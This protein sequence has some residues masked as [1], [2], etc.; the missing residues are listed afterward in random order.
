MCFFPDQRT[1]KLAT[2]KAE[3][4]RLVWFC[5]SPNQ[6]ARQALKVPAKQEGKC[7]FSANA[8]VVVSNYSDT[9]GFQSDTAKLEKVIKLGAVKEV[10]CK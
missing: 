8:S 3:T 9:D 5:F 2:R 6:E 10:P 4:N 1:A 7:G